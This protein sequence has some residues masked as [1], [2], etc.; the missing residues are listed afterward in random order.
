MPSIMQIVLVF[1]VVLI[2]VV[3]P[4]LVIASKRVTGAAK[5]GWFVGAVFFSWIAFILFIILTRDQKDQTR[6]QKDA[7]V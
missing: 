3:P 4:V 6:D 5:F 1:V 2:T 7:E